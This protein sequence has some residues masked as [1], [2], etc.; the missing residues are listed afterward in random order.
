M[1]L[2]GLSGPAFF[3]E[4]YSKTFFLSRAIY[5]L[6]SRISAATSSSTRIIYVQYFFSQNANSRRMKSSG[7]GGGLKSAPRCVERGLLQRLLSCDFASKFHHNITPDS[8]FLVSSRFLDPS[9][10]SFSPFLSLSLTLFILFSC[11]NFS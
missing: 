3:R 10:A 7:A 8:D 5:S 4:K 2:R 11:E 9:I 6:V 1:Q